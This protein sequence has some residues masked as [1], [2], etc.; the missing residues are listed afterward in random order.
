MW[1]TSEQK[2]ICWHDDK[3]K[4]YCIEIQQEQHQ[5]IIKRAVLQIVKCGLSEI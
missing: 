3:L 1:K 2:G 5:G 4:S